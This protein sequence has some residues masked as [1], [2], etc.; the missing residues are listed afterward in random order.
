[1]K[2]EL[3]RIFKERHTNNEIEYKNVLGVKYIQSILIQV[4]T[5]SPKQIKAM[6]GEITPQLF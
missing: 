5:L 4:Q 2:K 3:N 1:M 6:V